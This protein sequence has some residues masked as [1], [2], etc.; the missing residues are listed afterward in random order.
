MEKKP[1]KPKIHPRFAQQIEH[2]NMTLQERLLSKLEHV[3]AEI[4]TG[5]IYHAPE[6]AMILVSNFIGEIRGNDIIATG[7]V[8]GFNRAVTMLNAEL[9]TIKF[10]EQPKQ[11]L[12]A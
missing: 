2:W 11:R 9:A 12:S 6:K 5:N 10:I 1:E 8:N 4:E 3:S 7:N